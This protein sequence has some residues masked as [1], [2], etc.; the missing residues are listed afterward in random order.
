M[1]NCEKLKFSNY[2][3]WS[4]C[5]IVPDILIRHGDRFEGFC[6]FSCYTEVLKKKKVIQMCG[7]SF[8]GWG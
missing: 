8:R 5:P 4:D 3:D 7:V 6:E 2:A 1:S